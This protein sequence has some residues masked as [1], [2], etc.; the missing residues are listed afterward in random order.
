MANVIDAR[1]RFAGPSEALGA[2]AYKLRRVLDDARPSTMLQPYARRFVA[3]W[4]CGLLLLPALAAAGA[5]AAWAWATRDDGG[6]G[7]VVV[8]VALVAL[9]CA[10]AAR[11]A[12]VRCRFGPVDELRVRARAHGWCCRVACC[13]RPTNEEELTCQLRDAAVVVGRGWGFFL[14]RGAAT[15][16]GGARRLF[17]HAFCGPVEAER[18][19]CG[20]GCGGNAQWWRAGT[21]IRTV[22]RAFEARKPALTFAT[23]PTMDDISVG[24]WIARCNHGNNGNACDGS[25]ACVRWLCVYDRAGGGAYRGMDVMRYWR[26]AAKERSRRCAPNERFDALEERALG[27]FVITHVCF[28]LR[29]LVRADDALYKSADLLTSEPAASWWLG[30]DAVLRVCF[31][32]SGRTEPVGVRWTAHGRGWA[33]PEGAHR[34]PHLCSRLCLFLQADVGSVACW[35]Y[36]K[37]LC[38]L[39]TKPLCWLCTKPARAPDRKPLLWPDSTKEERRCWCFESVERWRALVSR[40]SANRWMPFVWPFQT[41]FIACGG[42]INFEIIVRVRVPVEPHAFL[43]LVR[44]ELYWVHRNHGGRTEVRHGKGALLFLDCSFVFDPNAPARAPLLEEL[45]KALTPLMAPADRAYA[46]HPGKFTAFPSHASSKH[47][48]VGAHDLYAGLDAK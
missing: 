23:H 40:A 27:R 44:H 29:K 42:W 19:P 16:Q 24:A 18:V 26:E 47:R 48:R 32:G 17:L 25:S 28:D 39:Y 33:L 45:L 13:D 8:V 10:C 4:L 20:P 9:A 46:L 6:D 41:A 15:A 37:P 7:A 36:T 1:S 34:D 31:Q 30:N 21:T 12:C 35:L 43:R 14:K 22:A 5:S 3:S 38:W 11:C 2:R